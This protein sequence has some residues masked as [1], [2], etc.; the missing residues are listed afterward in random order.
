MADALERSVVP[1]ALRVVGSNDAGA[2]VVSLDAFRR[3][4][5]ARPHAPSGG[6]AA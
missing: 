2:D 6:P 3:V 4:P 5:V 1:P